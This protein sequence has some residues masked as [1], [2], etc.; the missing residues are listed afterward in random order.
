MINKLRNI[1][2]I[3]CLLCCVTHVS[4]AKDFQKDIQAVVLY[5]LVNYIF[6]PNNRGES[7]HHICLVNDAQME[8]YLTK[9]QKKAKERGDIL[10]IHK[11]N[12]DVESYLKNNICHVLFFSDESAKKNILKLAQLH[13]K[14]ILTVSA[15]KNFSVNG[16][17]EFSFINERL[18]L[19]LNAKKIKDAGLQAS[20][21]LLRVSKV[22]EK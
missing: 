11:I 9:I 13:K 5:K 6:W 21:K 18:R 14:N 15:A 7:S 20:S 10:K 19:I 8:T 22:V 2:L 16:G 1:L 12:G 3:S 4:Y 17:V